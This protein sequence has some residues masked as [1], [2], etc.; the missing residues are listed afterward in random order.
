MQPDEGCLS[1][2]DRLDENAASVTGFSRRCRD[3]LEDLLDEHR[4]EFM[5]GI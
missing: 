5:K 1:I 3:C 4:S 2:L